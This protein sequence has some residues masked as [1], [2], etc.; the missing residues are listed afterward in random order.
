MKISIFKKEAYEQIMHFEEKS[1][2]MYKYWIQM[3][4]RKYNE[5]YEFESRGGILKEEKTRVEGI[6][7]KF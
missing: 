2:K 4:K 6:G 7:F 5:S 1:T 3:Y